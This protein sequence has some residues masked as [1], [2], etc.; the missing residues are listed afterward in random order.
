LNR[1]KRISNQILDEYESSFTADFEHN[2]ETLGKVTIIKSK[3]LRN[4]IAGYITNMM[5]TGESE[6]VSETS[7][8]SSGS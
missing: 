5:N 1:I 8:E 4:E 7:E 6:D 3:Q 2:K